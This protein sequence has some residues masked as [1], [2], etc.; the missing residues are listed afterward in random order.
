MKQETRQRIVD[1]ARRHDY[2]PSTVAVNLRRSRTG[3]VGVIVPAIGMS[4][5]STIVEQ[6]EIVAATHDFNV[7]LVTTGGNF[8][9]EK[10]AVRMLLQRRVE[11]IVAIPFGPRSHHDCRH[12]STIAEKTPVVVAE[13]NVPGITMPKVTVDNLDGARR[14]TGHLLDLGHRS[15]MMTVFNR[16]ESNYSG[17]D[18][19]AGYRAAFTDA[20]LKADE[21]M[22][23]DFT[24][25]RIPELADQIKTGEVTAIF[26]VCDY[27]AMEIIAGLNR[28]GIKTPDD[29]SV[30]GF[31]DIPAA[32]IYLPALTTVAQPMERLGRRT[33]EILFERL[34]DKSQSVPTTE[35]LPC[36]L[37]TRDSCRAR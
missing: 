16:D 10:Q 15:I 14:L 30:A 1:Y 22:I 25:A 34:A 12:F 18:R 19:I 4:V 2:A 8:E 20:G 27:M 6:V 11:G 5:F 24:P 23:V 32:A 35:I 7:I 36:T 28:L 33:A 21:Q 17:L 37:I 9:R 26:A 29:V 13:Q 31:D 3:T